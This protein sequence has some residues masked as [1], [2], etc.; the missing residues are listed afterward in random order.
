LICAPD[1]LHIK[2]AAQGRIS[3]LKYFVNTSADSIYTP[4]FSFEIIDT[5]KIIIKQVLLGPTG[6]V[7][8]I[9]THLNI[10]KGFAPNAIAPLT[11]VSVID[12]SLI[13][14]IWD[15][16][17]NAENYQLFR[18]DTLVFKGSDNYFLDS[19]KNTSNSIYNYYLNAIDA[20]NKESENSPA[21]NNMVLRV[22]NQNNEAAILKWSPYIGWSN[23]VSNYVIEE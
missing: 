14:I 23:G 22:Q 9:D 16:F 15:S 4:D 2:S 5:S 20:C 10:R 18:D 1:S 8:Q 7:T 12:S 19:Q 21:M 3:S 6:C 13:R 17:P 11:S